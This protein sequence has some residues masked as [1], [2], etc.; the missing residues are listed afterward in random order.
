MNA[1]GTL[2]I[3]TAFVFLKNISKLNMT[4]TPDAPP[5]RNGEFQ[6]SGTLLSTFTSH[7][8]L[9][10]FS[11][12]ESSR[13]KGYCS[14]TFSPEGSRSSFHLTLFPGG[15]KRQNY[16]QVSC[17]IRCTG[18]PPSGISVKYELT[19][20]NTSGKILKTG[21]NA[22]WQVLHSGS[23]SGFPNFISREELVQNLLDDVLTVSVEGT[24][25]FS[26]IAVDG[27]TKYAPDV[28]SPYA[29]LAEDFG[30]LLGD[31]SSC[32]LKI[33]VVNRGYIR[34]QNKR[35]KVDFLPKPMINHVAVHSAILAA[36]CGH[37]ASVLRE[38]TAADNQPIEVS[39]FNIETIN[40]LLKFIY[41]GR[42]GPVS[43]VKCLKLLKAA[44]EYG[45]EDLKTYCSNIL[46]A[47]IDYYNASLLLHYADIFKAAKLKKYAT[48][49][50]CKN[51]D[52]VD[53]ECHRATFEKHPKVMFAII[54]A[55]KTF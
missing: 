16:G 35:L 36:R 21:T 10:Q 11:T 54:D 23:D 33:A 41:T 15:E 20:Q 7:W 2:H 6:C 40:L 27:K 22:T 55:M 31:A 28:T 46:I 34:W 3:D 17:F 47:R 19:L 38:R 24:C 4:D 14:S 51:K 12:S 30:S 13:G 18:S 29:K 37:F 25:G 39:N 43:T 1:V 45:M 9:G 50:F 42:I 8:K 53:L 26:T 52:F 44:N 49:F 32:D 5:L 48:L